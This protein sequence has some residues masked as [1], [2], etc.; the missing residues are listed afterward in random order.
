[1]EFDDAGVPF[2][3]VLDDSASTRREEKDPL[4]EVRRAEPQGALRRR[5]RNAAGPCSGPI[6][7]TIRPTRS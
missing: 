7:P 3:T 5:R 4:P 2:H 1:M 6:S